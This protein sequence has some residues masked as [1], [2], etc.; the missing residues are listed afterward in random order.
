LITSGGS[1]TKIR[2][3]R[4]INKKIILELELS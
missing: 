1:G 3:I 2:N 4:F